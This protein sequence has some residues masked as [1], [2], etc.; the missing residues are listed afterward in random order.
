MKQHTSARRP[1]RPAPRSSK[2]PVRP[3]LRD[4]LAISDEKV[5]PIRLGPG[6]MPA[7]SLAVINE[8]SIHLITA[9]ERI[10]NL[11]EILRSAD[12]DLTPDERL[13]LKARYIDEVPHWGAH[14]QLGWDVPHTERVRSSIA[15]KAAKG[16]TPAVGIRR[17]GGD[18]SVLS[19]REQLA[20]G[21]RLWSLALLDPELV[22][23]IAL[24]RRKSIPVI[25]FR[26][27][28]VN[29]GRGVRWRMMKNLIGDLREKLR[30]QK[31]KLSKLVASSRPAIAAVQSAGIELQ[32][33]ESARK[34]DEMDALVVDGYKPD[35]SLQARVE[36]AEKKHSSAIRQSEVLDGAIARLVIDIQSTEGEIVG[37]RAE[38]FLEESREPMRKA[39]RQL[40]DLAKTAAV[41]HALAVANGVD[42]FAVASALCPVDPQDPGARSVERSFLIQAFNACLSAKASNDA[43]TTPSRWLTEAAAGAT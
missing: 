24:E 35:R 21:R 15:E 4:P 5:Q 20:S 6:R 7:L 2:Q 37:M 29:Q 36:A 17:T 11:N 22:E 28:A 16:C 27:R 30:S 9:P 23:V 3:P 10:T 18:S 38:A 31:E 1:A 40:S 32:G 14:T 12:P 34:A 42:G 41:I 13:Y 39:R 25:P 26:F 19:F 43:Y 33:L 8:A